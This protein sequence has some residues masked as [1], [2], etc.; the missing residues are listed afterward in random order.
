MN[1]SF[2]VETMIEI[3][4]L[5]IDDCPSWQNGLN[6]LKVA[7]Q[8][9]GIEANVELVKVMDNS[10]ANRLKFLGSPSFHIGGQDLWPEERES[11]SLSCRIYHTLQGLKGYPS[12]SMLRD[13][14]RGFLEVRDIYH[15]TK[16]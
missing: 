10:D 1:S 7:L 4:L 8:D 11:Y 3:E 16:Q 6:N 2:T 15:A 13:A 14:L 12:V 9:E 5:H